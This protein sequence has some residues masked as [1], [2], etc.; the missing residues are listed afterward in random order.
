MPLEVDEGFQDGDDEE[1]DVEAM[2]Q[3]F[4][5]AQDRPDVR[6]YGYSAATVV[7]N[8]PRM[9]KKISRRKRGDEII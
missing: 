4:R 9:R 3:N 2:L 1:L 7:Y 6:K 5:R 8:R